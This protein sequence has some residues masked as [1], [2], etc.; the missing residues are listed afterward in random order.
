MIHNTQDNATIRSIY[1]P[2][3]QPQFTSNTSLH[4]I[5]SQSPFHFSLFIT[6]QYIPSF[7][8]TQKLQK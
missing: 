8:A 1:I 7:L 3:I 5:L 2:F 6:S 4:F